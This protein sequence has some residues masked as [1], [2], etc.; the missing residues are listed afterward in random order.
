MTEGGKEQEE[1][2]EEGDYVYAERRAENGGESWER[3]GRFHT[4]TH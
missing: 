2:Y 3:G 4:L 1:G